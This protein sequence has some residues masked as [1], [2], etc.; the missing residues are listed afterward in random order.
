MPWHVMY[1]VPLLR[2]DV[3]LLKRVSQLPGGGCNVN[4]C[5]LC[6]A[7]TMHLSAPWGVAAAA[8]CNLAEPRRAALLVMRA[9][10]CTCAGHKGVGALGG[11]G[12][13]GGL[14]LLATTSIQPC[15]LCRR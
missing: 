8:G 13:G 4:G 12:C 6:L 2:A 7:A 1:R 15:T 14:S 11:A 10:H 9:W 3:K 5:I